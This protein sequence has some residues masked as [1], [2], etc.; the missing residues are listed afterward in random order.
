[1]ATS[2]F[3]LRTRFLAL[4]GLLALVLAPAAA[5]ATTV[6]DVAAALRQDPVYNQAGASRALSADDLAE[7][8]RRIHD[9]DTPIFV[10]VLPEA[11][12]AS[13]GG[14][15]DDLLQAIARKTG[16]SG[17]YALV[18]DHEFRT[19]SLRE[20]NGAG[21]AGTLAFQAH[22]ADGTRAV[23]DDFVDRVDDLHAASTG[24]GRGSAGG[25]FGL[26]WFWTLFLAAA[27]FFGI[28]RVVVGTR[29]SRQAAA[30]LAEVSDVAR[31]DLY[32]LQ[33][34]IVELDT[35]YQPG[36]DAETDATYQ[37]AVKELER[38][39]RRLDKAG[40]VRDLGVVSRAVEE[41][42]YQLACTRARIAKKELPARTAPCFFNPQHGPSTASVWWT[43]PDGGAARDVPACDV[44]AHQVAEG[45]E[46]AAREITVG[47][48]RVPHW[49]A[50]RYYA[51][52]MGGYYGWPGS[53]FGLGQVFTG[54][55]IGDALAGGFGHQGD[56]GA[57][58]VGSDGGW[59][60]GGGGDFGGG[61]S[62]GDSGGGWFGGGG[63]DWGGG[64][65]GD[66]GG[67]GG[68]SGGGGGGDSGGGSW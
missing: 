55:I 36:R 20:G 12:I 9:A 4:L 59:I 49:Q 17:A 31:E 1:M 27:A 19:G 50:P 67:G 57:A 65:G 13:N 58:V 45:R 46:P 54:F 66:F 53:G 14:N 30:E 22:K 3:M 29:R 11:A 6:A 28:R 43:P 68:D 15:A 61:G 10:A 60:G 7:L 40:S 39:Q 63:G 34:D 23:L 35:S 8:R 41:G 64:G 52:W 56:A 33:S 51:P 16:L 26:G 48:A 25:L 44:C 37:V 18:T 62:S 24:A 21:E 2:I 32:R 47:D 38:A 5:Q 42:R